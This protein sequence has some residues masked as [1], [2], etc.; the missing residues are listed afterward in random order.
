MDQIKGKWEKNFNF[1]FIEK[2][3]VTLILANVWI[4]G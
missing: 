3:E 1:L 4:L 2:Y